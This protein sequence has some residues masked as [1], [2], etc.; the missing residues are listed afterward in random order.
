MWLS[1][2]GEKTYYRCDNSGCCASLDILTFLNVTTLS[3][4]IM[5]E[6]TSMNAHCQGI[7]LVEWTNHKEIIVHV[8]EGWSGFVPLGHL[9]DLHLPQDG[10][11]QRWILMLQKISHGGSERAEA[12][13][14]LGIQGWVTV[15]LFDICQFQF[16]IVS[17]WEVFTFY[18]L[19]NNYNYLNNH[20]LLQVVWCYWPSHK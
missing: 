6:I 13:R 18:H 15:P 1:G 12:N 4:Y 14:T 11:E 17:F 2:E 8:Q 3:H 20:I 7:K 16:W 10:D 19:T 9:P 5:H